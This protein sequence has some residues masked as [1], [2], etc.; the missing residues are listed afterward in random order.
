MI[1]KILPY[2]FLTHMHLQAQAISLVWSSF[3]DFQTLSLRRQQQVVKPLTLFL[4]IVF[5]FESDPDI[6]IRSDYLE[7]SEFE[8]SVHRQ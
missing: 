5:A 6:T 8:K 3:R 7:M 1:P 2:S 4:E